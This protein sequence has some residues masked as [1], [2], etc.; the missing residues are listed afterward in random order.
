MKNF[1]SCSIFSRIKRFSFYIRY[2]QY[3]RNQIL[4]KFILINVIFKI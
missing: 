2:T 4:T 3:I 1:N